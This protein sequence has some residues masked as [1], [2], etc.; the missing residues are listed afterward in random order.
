MESNS[1]S[2]SLLCWNVFSILSYYC[3]WQFVLKSETTRRGQGRSMQTTVMRAEA[4]AKTPLIL[5]HDELARLL[6]A[7]VIYLAAAA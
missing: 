7:V 5:C 1:H 3:R 4:E 2:G 6:T